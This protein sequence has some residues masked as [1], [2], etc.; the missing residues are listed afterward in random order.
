[1][2]KDVYQAMVQLMANKR[3]PLKELTDEARL[4]I[5]NA[6]LHPSDRDVLA[7]SMREAYDLGR[8]SVNAELKQAMVANPIGGNGHTSTPNT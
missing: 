1:M 4:R 6:S 2:T 5:A 3:N 7:E 8:A